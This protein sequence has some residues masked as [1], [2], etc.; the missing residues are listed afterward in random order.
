MLVKIIS[1][2]YCLN[3]KIKHNLCAF[4]YVNIINLKRSCPSKQ[5]PNNGNEQQ[6]NTEYK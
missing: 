4:I 6:D 3:V 2:H 1:I 5:G